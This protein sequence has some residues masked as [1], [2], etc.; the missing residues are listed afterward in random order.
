MVG[1]KEEKAIKIHI[2]SQRSP[3]KRCRKKKKKITEKKKENSRENW[4]K[5][6]KRNRNKWIDKII[7]TSKTESK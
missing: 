7:K 5:G 4:K 3:K 1:R 6:T 2:A